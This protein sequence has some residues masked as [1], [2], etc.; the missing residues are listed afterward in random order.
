MYSPYQGREE[1]ED[2]LYQEE[3][4]DDS[5]G[6]EAYS[7]VEFRLYS[8]LHYSSNAGEMD[9][10]G[11]TPE[12]QDSQ[13]PEVTV[14]A[15][16]E[17]VHTEDCELPSSE[18]QQLLKKKK[19]GEKRDKQKK[20]KSD[21]KGQ[22]SSSSVFEEVIVIDSSPDVISISE[23]DTA[24]D[25]G[26]CIMKGQGL[27][28]LQTSTPTQQGGQ[29]REMSLNMPVSVDSSSSESDS[30]S[31]ESISESDSSESSDSE[32]L[33]NWMILGRGKQVE[34][35]SISLNL[36]GESNSNTGV[37]LDAEEEKQS[38]WVVSDKDKDAQIF[39]KDK[40]ARIVTQRVPNRYYTNKS[41]QCRNCN[42]TGHLSKNCPEPK[43][44]TSCYLCGTPGHMAIE[45]PYKHCNNCGLPGHLYESC[46]ERPYWHK[47]CHR[48]SMKGH[49]FDACPEIWRQ[50]HIT[51]KTGP[52]VKQMEEDNGRSPAFC[53]N[54]SRKGHFGHTCTRQRMFNGVYAT[55]PFINH[56]D[57]VED[58][59]RRQHRL[60]LRVKEL[61]KNGCLFNTCQTPGPPKKKPKFSHQNNHQQTP[62][63]HKPSGSHIFFSD[64]DL[65]DTAPKT[66]KFN[67]I[68]PQQSTG[69]VKPWKPKRP[70]P[71]SRDPLPSS[72]LIFDE[73]DDF[74]RGGGQGGN[75]EK[76]SR[77][78][79]MKKTNDVPNKGHRDS[80][81]D[82]LCWTVTGVMK[83]S[84]SKKEVR[85]SSRKR[86]NRARS[87]AHKQKGD[88]SSM[89]PTDENL[90][91]IKQKRKRK[92]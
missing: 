54:C 31:S 39:N 89:Y 56:Y 71:T 22:R 7:E 37:S 28:R 79:K 40:G 15:D 41:V 46:S 20:G 91:I 50:Y 74:P 3:A 26:V 32:C 49:F 45:C 62:H 47:Q 14:D 42:K 64:N 78:K 70:V 83:G 48:C 88:D 86:R 75:T 55:V 65:R 58:I 72:K 57:S 4:N 2:D 61:K 81:P 69:N 52:P 19:V 21:P 92:R 51:N 17:L 27:H 25:E 38:T 67:K 13:Q 1:L 9:D 29:K 76:K 24:D 63:S 77:R 80:R 33:E 10:R 84:G 44:L 85:E 30:D 36:E 6:S 8:Q 82:R 59:N 53:F 16:G 90:F 66:N 11:E 68:K 23:D 87:F 60:K 73:A 18:Q 12:D 34:D 35:R 43:K 5:D